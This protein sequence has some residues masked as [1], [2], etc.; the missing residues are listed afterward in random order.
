[1]GEHLSYSQ[2]ARSEA[3]A[4]LKLRS[5]NAR[6]SAPEASQPPE[7]APIPTAL[8]T[9]RTTK[10]EQPLSASLLGTLKA[11]SLLFDE[12]WY[13]TQYPDV[14][15]SNYDPVQHY[16]RHGAAEGRNPN[17]YFDTAWYLA[18]NKDV[19]ASGMNPFIHY[20]LYGFR[21]G[22]QPREQSGNVEKLS[23]ERTARLS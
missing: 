20:L 22:R 5:I 12:E 3:A 7:K 18:Q 19:V 6:G 2:H 10:D 9:K 8:Q 21:E 13:R 23:T 15:A 14:G 17:P 4:R 11:R 16:L 1:M